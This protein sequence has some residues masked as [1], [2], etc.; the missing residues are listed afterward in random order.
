MRYTIDMHCDYSKKRKRERK[1]RTKQNK[2][3][4]RRVGHDRL[5]TRWVAFTKYL[6]FVAIDLQGLISSGVRATFC[7]VLF[8][9][10]ATILFMFKQKK[11]QISINSRRFFLSKIIFY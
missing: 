3:I 11:K 10:L 5:H 6:L 9:T 2:F 1:E 8:H 4:R 7:D